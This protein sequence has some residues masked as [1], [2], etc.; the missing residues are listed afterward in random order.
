EP[1]TCGSRTASTRVAAATAAPVSRGARSARP[2]GRPVRTPARPPAGSGPETTR[3]EPGDRDDD[4]A[5][6]DDERHPAEHDARQRHALVVRLAGAH[7]PAGLVADD[8]G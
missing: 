1:R 4:H 7:G 6:E 3:D 5:G 8:D 2:A